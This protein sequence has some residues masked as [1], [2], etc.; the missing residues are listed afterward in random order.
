M[1]LY[2]KMSWH[3]NSWCPFLFLVGDFNYSKCSCIVLVLW[4]TISS[5]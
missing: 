2:L 3:L 1:L 4:K 5:L